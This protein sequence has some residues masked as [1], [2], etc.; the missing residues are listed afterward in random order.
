ML[1]ELFMDVLPVVIGIII[2]ALISTA[3]MCYYGIFMERRTARVGL[4]EAFAPALTQID[5]ARHNEALDPPQ[6]GDIL[7]DMLPAQSAA[8]EKLWPYV[9]DGVAYQ[10]AWKDYRKAA[11]KDA[12]KFGTAG[13]NTGADEPWNFIESK[14]QAILSFAK[15]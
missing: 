15:S 9:S 8:I 10:K 7:E 14:I 12:W 6:I 3:S 2:G 11:S 13:W 1:T 5:L 4:H